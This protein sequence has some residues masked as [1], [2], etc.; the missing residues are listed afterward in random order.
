MRISYLFLAACNAACSSCEDKTPNG[1][2]SAS[3]LTSAVLTAYP[4]ARPPAP[5]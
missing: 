3:G 4:A 2:T 1:S 5:G